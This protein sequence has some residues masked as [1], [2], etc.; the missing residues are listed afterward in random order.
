MFVKRHIDTHLIF[1]WSF[2]G[3]TKRKLLTYKGHDVLDPLHTLWFT[4]IQTQERDRHTYEVCVRERE[5]HSFFSVSPCCRKLP[6]WEIHTSICASP[7]RS[8]LQ[9]PQSRQFYPFEVAHYFQTFVRILAGI[10]VTWC[11]HFCH[12]L[13]TQILF[14]QLNRF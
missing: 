2:F 10:E 12:F 11:T 8:V 4:C 13:E 1:R 3:K 6:S 14:R 5:I 9:I 7:F